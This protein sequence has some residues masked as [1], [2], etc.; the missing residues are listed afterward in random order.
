MNRPGITRRTLL[1]GVGAVVT[2]SALGAAATSKAAAEPTT[3]TDVIGHFESRHEPWSVSLGPEYGTASGGFE[4]VTDVAGSGEYAGKL[5]ADF[6][7]NG[8]YVSLVKTLDHLNITKV[9]LKVRAE[10][11]TRVTIRLVNGSKT[12]VQGF[13]AVSATASDWQDVEVT[14]FNGQDGFDDVVTLQVQ[15]WKDYL[16][17]GAQR[18]TQWLDDIRV[19]H[20]VV[21]VAPEKLET[22]GLPV[23]LT[24]DA[25][26]MPLTVR[27]LHDDE[28]S[29]DVTQHSTLTTSNPDVVTV[30][31]YG[32][33]TPLSSGTADIDVE[34][35]GVTQTFTVDVRE[36]Q[37]LELLRSQDGRLLEGDRAVGFTGFNYDLF[38]LSYP[39]RA[40]WTGIDADISLMASW[41]L[42]AVRVPINI[43]MIQSAR[44]VFPDDDRWADELRTRRLN[45]E[46]MDMLDYFVERAGRHGVRVI[47]DWHRGPVDPYDYWIGG[48]PSDAGT[49]KEGTAIAYLAPSLTERGTF[50]LSDT[51]HL[52][53]L[54]D[55][56][57]WIT[58]HFRSDPNILAIEVPFNEPHDAHMSIQSNWRRITE[59]ASLAVKAA[60]PERLTF[61]LG[62]AYAHDTSA[63]APTWQIPNVVDGN[64]PH[65]YMPNA[66]IPTR[67]DA[68]DR[69]SPWLARDIDAVFSHAVASLFAPYSTSPVPVYNGEGGHYGFESFLPDMDKVEAADLMVEAALVQYYAAGAV[70]QLH[71]SLWHNANDFVPFQESFDRLYKRFSPV[72]AAGP[73]DWRA[74]KLA[75]IQ[76]PAAVPIANGHNWSVVPFVKLALD[77]H[78]G[79]FHLLTD[80]EVI[81]RLLT[82]VPTG[83]EQVDGFSAD[84]DYQAVVADR[85]NLD[86]RVRSVLERDDFETPILWV[87]DMAELGAAELARFLED[88]E[89]A[90]DRR[91]KADL[92]LVVGPE[93]LVVYRRAESNRGR[94]TVHPRI[95]RDGTFRLVDESGEDVFE[96]TSETLWR[97]GI[98]VEVEKWRSAIF[99]IAT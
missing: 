28:T 51:E 52:A 83:L 77:L 68:E 67:D 73:V 59:R 90:V 17:S 80:D 30:D 98:T 66:P 71:W 47:I 8:R 33:L 31:D 60:D 12:I 76:N 3:W 6:S 58:E 2:T 78:L 69:R 57:R 97:R 44:G 34:H 62:P 10:N 9:A 41:G 50:D 22:T 21:P 39:R 92:Q 48:T 13:A 70:G 26:P 11:V 45:T 20:T 35:L 74:A 95:P 14:T 23:L 16:V 54:L 65:H 94:P 96:G 46:W 4:R 64:A 19:E 49:G 61:A 81:D 63:A 84:F 32:Y 72:Y 15:I 89:I 53:V 38:M 24:D 5:T 91:T 43:G 85:R 27:A 37:A 55:T 82:Q 42:G 99:R 75:V 56:N 7:E 93:H 1:K 25:D 88:A 18:A 29:A 36:P 87:D 79:P 40:N 86:E